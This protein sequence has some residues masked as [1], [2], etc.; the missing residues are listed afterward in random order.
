MENTNIE[1]DTNTSPQLT[2]DESKTKM[3]FLRQNTYLK[4]IALYKK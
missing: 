4:L 1:D 3:T 2:D